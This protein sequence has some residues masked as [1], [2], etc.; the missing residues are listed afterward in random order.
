MLFR[1]RSI[2]VCGAWI[3]LFLAVGGSGCAVA[4][5]THANGLPRLTRYTNTL[6]LE[7]A[8]SRYSAMANDD[9]SQSPEVRAQACLGWEKMT[10]DLES[11]RRY[12]K[13]FRMSSE[14][15]NLLA[16]L[17]GLPGARERHPLPATCQSLFVQPP[18]AP[19][20]APP[21]PTANPVP[22]VAVAPAPS[23]DQAPAAQTLDAGA[24]SAQQP[25]APPMVAQA[26]AGPLPVAAPALPPPAAPVP[27]AAP[28]LTLPA[29]LLAEGTLWTRLRTAVGQPTT[30][31]AGSARS[32]DAAVDV[33]ELTALA[34]SESPQIRLR[35]RFHLLG[36][37]SNAIATLDRH[38]FLPAGTPGCADRRDREPLHVTQGR[39]LRSLMAAWRGRYPEPMSDLVVGLASYASRD[40]PVLDGPRLGR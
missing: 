40:N 19:V 7:W 29:H 34:Q 26:E 20:A 14:A 30:D 25:T 4:P 8:L 33:R 21:P 13:L 24:P 5:A 1:V 39:L 38:G 2:S 12:P 17:E 6:Q 37:C 23:M 9:A 36:L 27:P 28:T 32:G 31:G 11:A 16:M 10:F 3:S 22:P 15:S 18:A 35:A